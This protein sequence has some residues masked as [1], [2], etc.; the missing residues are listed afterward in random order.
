MRSAEWS[1]DELV[2]M[3]LAPVEPVIAGSVAVLTAPP[4][5]APAR[6]RVAG[7]RLATLPVVVL[8]GPD[9]SPAPGLPELVDAMAASDD[10]LDALVAGAGRHPVA[11]QSA[12]LLLRGSGRRSVE[13]GLVVESAVFSALQAGREHRSWR[14]RTPRRARHAVGDGPRVRV[15]RRG[16][17]LE[18][19]LARADAANA[20]DV[21][22]R[23]ELLEALA[24]VEADPALRVELRAEGPVFCSGGDLDEFGS[25]TD[26]AA[27]HLVRLRASIAAV[28]ARVGE[29]VTVLVQGPAAGSGVELAA[30]ARRVVAHPDAR[31]VLPELEL[32]LVPGAGG[33]VSL[34]RRIGRHRTAWLLLSGE[35]VDA[36]TARSWGLVD[37]IQV[38]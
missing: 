25:A 16:T 15:T 19:V 14:E 5:A 18:V 33:T 26:P 21:R 35:P 27:A 37:E 9:C 36:H 1:G 38:F 10:E 11:A 2:E 32:G 17:T 22:L 28:L 7:A 12:M 23:D 31:F 29:R 20:L 4:T 13:D 30:F 34:P 6:L 3:V 8:A 24:V